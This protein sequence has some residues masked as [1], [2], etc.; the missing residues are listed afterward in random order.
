M[1]AMRL[2]SHTP[3]QARVKADLR[4]SEHTADRHSHWVLKALALLSVL[5]LLGCGGPV[6]Q[7]VSDGT[8]GVAEAVAAVPD[9]E[10]LA[11]AAAANP[12]PTPTP[13]SVTNLLAHR[14]GDAPNDPPKAD[15]A[16][17]CG[18]LECEFSDRS[19]DTDG[20]IVG[21]LWEFDDGRTSHQRNPSVEYVAAGDRFVR[22]TVLDD[23]G[24][25]SSIAR[26]IFVPMLDVGI[27]LSASDVRVE[28][29][30]AVELSWEMEDLLPIDLRRGGR[31]IHS[32][33]GT[34]TA[35]VDV[36]EGTGDETHVYQVCV[37]ASNV[38]SNELRVTF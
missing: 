22:L 12:G 26:W 27:V 19:S 21:W 33:D 34:A 6:S 30:T 35:F 32:S 24:E 1:R 28:G 23:K 17:K 9:Q 18:A 36:V 15:F 37:L 7:L 16:E 2:G 29:S 3:V 14:R 10:V 20:A 5:L 25:T 8:S 11:F 31:I 4:P 38:C 13:G